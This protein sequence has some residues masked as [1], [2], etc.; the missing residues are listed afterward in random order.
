MGRSCDCGWAS[1]GAAN[2]NRITT[3]TNAFFIVFTRFN[4]KSTDRYSPP[5][6]EG[7]LSR[8]RSGVV[9]KPKPFGVGPPPAGS[10]SRSRGPPD[11]GGQSYGRVRSARTPSWN[12]HNQFSDTDIIVLIVGSKSNDMFSRR[13]NIG[14]IGVCLAFRIRNSVRRETMSAMAPYRLKF[15]TD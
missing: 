14:L 7:T 6:S 5:E 10:A 8:R 11:S 13:Q 9:P 4:S 1:A 3:E 15:P 2:A 12:S